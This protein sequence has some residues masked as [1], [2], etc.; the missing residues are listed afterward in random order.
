MDERVKPGNPDWERELIKKYLKP[1]AFSGDDQIIRKRKWESDTLPERHVMLQ[2]R[3]R[4]TRRR[5]L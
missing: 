4:D 5:K 1:N 2:K 3:V